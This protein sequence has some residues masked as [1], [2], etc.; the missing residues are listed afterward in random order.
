VTRLKKK[1]DNRL[2][3]EDLVAKSSAMRQV[4]RL[5][6]RAAQSNIRSSSKARAASARN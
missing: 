2:T 1:T 4:F 6:E 5:G 3:F